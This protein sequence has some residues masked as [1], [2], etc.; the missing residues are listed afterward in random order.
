MFMAALFII[1]K[2]WKQLKYPSTD[3]WINKIQY[4]HIMG[5]YSV[6]KR[7]E[8]LTHATTWMSFANIILRS[9]SQA[10]HIV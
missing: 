6:I 9:Q 10:L 3:E 4:I 5:Y 1:A 2:R 8:V 7:N